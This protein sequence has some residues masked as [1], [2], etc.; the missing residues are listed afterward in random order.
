MAIVSERL[1]AQPIEASVANAI[2]QSGVIG[3]IPF[4]T[5]AECA[6]LDR[7]LIDPD[8][9]PPLESSKGRAITDRTVYDIAT[10]P[11]LLDL[12]RP[13][14]GDDIVLWGASVVHRPPGNT[15]PWHTDIETAAPDAR[16]VSAWIALRHACRE[17]GMVFVAGSHRF[18]R[19]VQEIA[20][21]LGESQDMTDERVLDIA[22]ALEPSSALIQPDVRDGDLILF[23]GRIWHSG[24]N[25][26]A[27]DIR[28]A[29]LLQYAAADTPIPTPMERSYGWP[30]RF[31]TDRRMPTILVSGTAHRARNRLV[32]P[33]PRPA[34]NVPMITTVARTVPLP[35]PADPEKRW[36]PYPQFRGPTNACTMMSCHISVLSPGHCPHP[37]HLHAEE[38]LLV[39][40]DGEVEIELA[41]DPMRTNSRRHRMTPGM[42]SYYPATQHHTIHNV[43][44]APAN[45]LM[46][47]WN[48][49]A[50]GTE[51]PLETSIFQH[52]PAVISTRPMAQKRLFEQGTQLLSKLHA[53]LTTLQP[54]AGYE[55]H[56]DP[57]DVAIILLSGEVET[58]GERV[59]PLG[60]IFY[61]AG[62]MHGIQNVGA[63]PATYLVFEFHSPAATALRQKRMEERRLAREQH[64]LEKQRRKRGLR[65]VLR[66]VAKKARKLFAR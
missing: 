46:F 7:H 49:P 27:S 5:P 28:R 40:L 14:L 12:L 45:Y 36:R 66:K 60:V 26:G 9:P 55:P 8:L 16:A 22:R 18:G 64:R 48:A 56:A 29:L 32:P 20:A 24:R 62:E 1:H 63:T 61:S 42:F 6:A 59:R 51:E 47:K 53:H 65:G 17:S 57:Y 54:G 44:A 58:V 50:A 43:G 31:L 25:E 4:L 13:L 3:P 19:S 15:H 34:A 2:R 37:P 38:E 33:P 30:F 52:E 41:D 11:Q 23:D 35:L 21:G 39:V 10:R